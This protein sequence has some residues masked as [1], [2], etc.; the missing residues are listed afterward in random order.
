MQTVL[1]MSVANNAELPIKGDYIL[2]DSKTPGLGLRVY[3]SGNKSWIFQKKLGSEPVRIVLGP[4]PSLPLE[5]KYNQATGE[6]LKGARQLAEEA[7]AI[8]RHGL[9]PRLEKKKQ[10]L[11]TR[12]DISKNELTIQKAWEGYVEYKTLLPGKEKPSERTIEDWRKAALKLQS[13][14]VWNKPVID[15][16]GNDLLQEI[17]RLSRIVKSKSATNGGMTQASCIM[18]YLRAVFNYAVV[19]HKLKIDSPFKELNQLLPNWQTTK[20]RKRRIG[21]TEG[22]MAAWWQAVEALR[23]RKGQ[24]SMTIADWLQLSVFFGTRKTE[25]I[26]LEWTNVDL[27]N[28]LIILPETSTKARRAHVIPLTSH[29]LSIL[30][31][32]HQDNIDR[33]YVKRDGTHVGKSKWV[34][35]ASRKGKLTGEIGHLVSPDKS[36][37]QIIKSTGISFSAH[38]LRRTFATLLNEGGAS[39]ITVEKALNHAPITTSAKSYVNNP[40]ILKLRAI[41][42]SLED[43]I[44]EEAG[45][46]T[47]KSS[48]IEVSHEDYLLLMK[49]KGESRA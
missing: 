35:Q 14:S 9:D 28:K 23:S 4:A 45:V 8:I 44:L 46:K 36:I 15:L 48:T 38:D 19:A 10:L 30:K 12:D 32:R 43:A 21:E 31:R 34:F 29:V 18:R 13:S 16:A 40:R 47:N 6:T 24:D 33:D 11:K 2:R 49:I 17:T 39:D 1:T 22:S 26:S 5:S 42:Q 7:A 3:S 25:L 27:K 41:F 20:S 37:Q